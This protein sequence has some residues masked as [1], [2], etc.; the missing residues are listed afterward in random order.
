MNMER[1]TVM[2]DYHCLFCRGLVTPENVLFTQE[3][4]GGRFVDEK[5]W[6]QFN[7][8]GFYSNAKDSDAVEAVHMQ[9]PNLYY[10]VTKDNVTSKDVNGFPLSI[11]V[12]PCDALTPRELSVAEKVEKQEQAALEGTAG[13]P[14]TADTAG[15]I[16]NDSAKP[17]GNGFAPIAQRACPHCHSQLPMEFGTLPHHKVTFVGGRAA[18]KTAYLTCLVQQLSRQLPA[19]HLG[20]VMQLGD[21]E[22]YFSSKINYYETHGTTEPTPVVYNI[23]PLVFM[24]TNNNVDPVRSCFISINDIAGEGVGDINFMVNNAGLREAEILLMVI[25]PNQLNG[26]AYYDATQG[27]KADTQKQEA[28]LATSAGKECYQNDISAFL[29]NVGHKC[30]I[31]AQDIRH[32]IVIVTKFDMPL[33]VERG[34]FAQVDTPLIHDI[35]NATH[36]GC[37][38]A[39]VARQVHDDLSR[40]FDKEMGMRPNT[41]GLIHMIR[42]TFRKDGLTVD[43]TCASTCTLINVPANGVG[44][45]RNYEFEND[46]TPMGSKHRIIE[47]FLEI[48]ALCGMI[49]VCN[50]P[51][52]MNRRAPRRRNRR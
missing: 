1:G 48:L 52:V 44:N 50:G 37:L 2:S 7:K 29:A 45:P 24:Y 13:S 51:D 34:N 5:R 12:R 42:R 36:N 43:L 30:N 25:D 14:S 15:P 39:A 38:D 19:H 6:E 9:F 49:D 3:V 22:K 16:F 26:G 31:V 8:C 27:Q 10:R 46:Y 11:R 28:Q 32:I 33:M 35:G 23:Y 47:P 40:Y 20:T 4:K 17:T 21:S 18:G 41:H